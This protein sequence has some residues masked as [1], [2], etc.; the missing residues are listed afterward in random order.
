[1]N[2][3]QEEQGNSGLKRNKL[4]E[5]YGKTTSGDQEENH[6]EQAEDVVE[7]AENEWRSGGN[8]PW[9]RSALALKYRDFISPWEK[10]WEC[11]FLRMFDALGLSFYFLRLTP[12][13]KHTPRFIV[14]GHEST[15]WSKNYPIRHRISSCLF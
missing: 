15:S 10:R 12:V 7:R 1:M 2:W 13:C 5:H 8:K 4:V 11:L 3:S 9:S 6:G 14:I